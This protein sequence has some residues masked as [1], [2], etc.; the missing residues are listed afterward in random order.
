MVL[1]IQN[2]IC[3]NHAPQ[4]IFSILRNTSYTSPFNS[5]TDDAL[6][7]CLLE[8]AHNACNSKEIDALKVQLVHHD[9][10]YIGQ[11]QRDSTECLLVPKYIISKGSNSSTYPTRASLF[12]ILF[13]FVLQKY[14]ACD[15]C[16]LGP[17]SFESSCVLYIAPTYTFSMQDLILRR[18]QQKLQKS[19]FRCNKTTWHVESNSILQPPKYLL[20]I[21]NRWKYTKNNVTKDKCSI[22]MDT[23]VRL[24]PLKF[25]P[26]T[27]IDRHRQFTHSGHYAAY[28]SCWKTF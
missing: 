6:L 17:P 9:T 28:I 22:P 15:V 26:R 11:I 21:L 19:C 25:S 13:S 5:N 7:K 23:T 16:K 12:D 2:S 8:I 20:L 1:R 14:I 10:F 3:I 4:L 18:M 27:T 24:G